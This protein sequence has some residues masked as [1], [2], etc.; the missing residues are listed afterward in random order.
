MFRP[1]IHTQQ[2]PM[3][4]TVDSCGSAGVVVCGNI[5]YEGYQSPQSEQRNCRRLVGRS[6]VQSA[7]IYK[8][9]VPFNRYSAPVFCES[10][11]FTT[12]TFITVILEEN[13]G[14][15]IGRLPRVRGNNPYKLSVQEYSIPAP[16]FCELPI[17]PTTG[18]VLPLDAGSSRQ[19]PLLSAAP[20]SFATQG[21]ARALRRPPFPGAGYS[22]EGRSFRP[23]FFDLYF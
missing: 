20:V 23:R 10:S 6:R 11:I 4:S 1:H 16:I 22:T 9:G 12:Y 7:V 17:K 18:A 14:S 13:Y 8:E 2:H 15:R 19:R 5:V 3:L 21:A